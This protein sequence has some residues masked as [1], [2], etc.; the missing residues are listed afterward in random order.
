MGLRAM[1]RYR[2]Q[3]SFGHEWLSTFGCGAKEAMV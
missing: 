3:I 2:Y 1:Y